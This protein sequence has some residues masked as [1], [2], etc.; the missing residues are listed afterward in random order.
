M[1]ISD[2]SSDV[3]SS[4]LPI[5]IPLMLVARIENLDPEAV[6]QAGGRPV[7]Q[8]DGQL[9]P[10]RTLPGKGQATAAGLVLILD[11]GHRR[12][13]LGVDRVA[14]VVA[15]AMTIEQPAAGAGLAGVA[16][17]VGRP[18]AVVAHGWR[19][20]EAVAP[21]GRRWERRAVGRE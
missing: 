3:C 18:A 4:D 9:V 2:W 17:V 10:F 14:D 5:A 1:R 13:A 21:R 15:C 6:S 20:G 8:H 11:D 12:A 19:M 16:L 7:M